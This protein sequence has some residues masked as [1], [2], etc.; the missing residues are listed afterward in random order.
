MYDNKGNKN[1]IEFSIFST[2]QLKKKKS[3]NIVREN[4]G[5]LV[6]KNNTEERLNSKILDSFV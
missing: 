5:G 2:K 4:I 3:Q 1:I 6:S